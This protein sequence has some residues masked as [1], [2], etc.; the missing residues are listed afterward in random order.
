[1]MR[2]TRIAVIVVALAAAILLALLAAD[3]HSW[4]RALAAGDGVYDSTPLVARWTPATRLPAGWSRALVGVSDD[5]AARHALQLYRANVGAAVSLDNATQV[6]TAR[7][8]AENALAH[9]AQGS[10]SARASEAETLLGVLAFTDYSQGAQTTQAAQAV[11]AFQQA[12]KDDPADEVAKYDLELLLRL[13]VA[14]GQ[15]VGSQ[16]GVGTGPGKRGAGGGVAGK[17]Y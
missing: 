1:M 3:V 17:G 12:V 5:L 15:R 16:S 7:G 13:L 14:H 8:Q 2:A 11:S 6:A 10:D 4:P 9:V